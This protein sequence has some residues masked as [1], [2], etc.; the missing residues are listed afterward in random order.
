MIESQQ[1]HLR[2]QRLANGQV[3]DY[4]AV[5]KPEVNFLINPGP[6]PRGEPL[7]SFTISPT[8]PAGLTSSLLIRRPD[9]QSAEQTLIAANAQI[10]VARVDYFPQITLAA[11]GGFQSP[12]LSNASLGQ[13]ACGVSAAS[14]SSPPEKFAQMSG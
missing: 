4:W 8:V 3:A 9:I 12:A 11:S 13:P 6:I 14:P 2:R 10:A 7:A 5:T 1:N